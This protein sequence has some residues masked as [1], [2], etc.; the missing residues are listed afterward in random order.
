MSD[1]SDSLLSSYDYSLDPSFIAQQPSDPRHAARLMI[2][3]EQKVDLPSVRHKTIWDWKD[4]LSP[5]DLIVLN[6]T[7]VLKARLRVRLSGG[8]LAELFLLE[9]L[10]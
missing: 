6:D 4:E 3:E 5:G 10:D 1:P 8:G 7:R 2:V 9:H